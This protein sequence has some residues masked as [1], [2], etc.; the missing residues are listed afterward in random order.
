MYKSSR[1]SESYDNDE[2][3]QEVNK[4]TKGV[5]DNAD[6]VND[7]STSVMKLIKEVKSDVKEMNIDIQSGLNILSQDSCWTDSNLDKLVESTKKTQQEVSNLSAKM[8]KISTDT[9]KREEAHAK[10][11]ELEGHSRNIGTIQFWRA[12]IEISILEESN[13]PY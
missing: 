5:C 2:I 1:D 3:N 8:I 4:L 9:A 12:K 7:L 11:I 6:A 10:V 13:S